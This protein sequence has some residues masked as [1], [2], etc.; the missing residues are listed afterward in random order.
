MKTKLIAIG[1]TVFV[2]ET[3]LFGLW[4]YL[5]KPTP[6]ISI[7]LIVIIPFI[8]GLSILIG[9]FLLWFKV[10]HLAK[11]AFL[12]SIIGPLIFYFLWTMWFDGWRERNYKEYSFNIDSVKFEVSLSR[13]S[14]YF[15][16]SDIT[17]QPNGS[18]T[19]LFFGEYQTKGDTIILVDGQTKMKITN[20]K[21][22]SFPQSETEIELSEVT[23]R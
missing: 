4:I 2:V 7:A 23:D 6:D 1:L 8:F 5:N 17:N 20:N 12:N 21:L 3:L 16:I 22:F 14:N 18:T 15:S 13:T 9:L 11:I 10:G 19:G